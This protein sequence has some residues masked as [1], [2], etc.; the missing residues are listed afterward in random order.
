VVFSVRV[1]VSECP[2]AHLLQSEIGCYC[3]RGSEEGR[4]P[5]HS[6]KS[7]TFYRFH[8]FGFDAHLFIHLHF[9]LSIFLHASY[10]FKTSFAH[11]IR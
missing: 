9:S 11:I 5:F 7:L 8:S 10:F 6:F 4:G 3:G 1:A 2:R